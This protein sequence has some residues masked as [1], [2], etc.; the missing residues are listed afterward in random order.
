[1]SRDICKARACDQRVG[2]LSFVVGR[3]GQQEPGRQQVTACRYWPSAW[4]GTR[5]RVRPTTGGSAAR[6]SHW[7]ASSSSC[8]R[9]ATCRCCAYGDMP[10]VITSL[11]RGRQT[12]GV[13]VR[14]ALLPSQPHSNEVGC[15][16]RPSAWREPPSVIDRRGL[17]VPE[18]VSLPAMGIGASLRDRPDEMVDSVCARTNARLLARYCEREP[19]DDASGIHH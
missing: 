4:R 8:G 9:S 5:C 13:A 17:F 7:S 6:R 16:L 15:R 12:T 19:A 14:A 10:C 2:S 1:M 11:S 3:P 18:S